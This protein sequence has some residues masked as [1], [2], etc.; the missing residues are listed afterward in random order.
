MVKPRKMA[1]MLRIGCCRS[2]DAAY[3][4]CL[5]KNAIGAVAAF[6]DIHKKEK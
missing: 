3:A 5:E 6:A 1:K 2:S 4:E